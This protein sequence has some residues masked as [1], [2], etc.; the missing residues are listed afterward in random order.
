M[1]KITIVN[2]LTAG[3]IVCSILLL[4]VPAFSVPFYIFYAA[5]GI[6]DMIDGTVARKTHTTSA[7]GAKLDSAADLVF[8]AVC[9][10]RILPV[11]SLPVW[12]LVW[13]GVIVIIR[14][15]GAGIR[16]RKHRRI[17]PEHSVMNKVSGAVVFAVP[18]LLG[19]T[20]S[21]PVKLAGVVVACALATVGAVREVIVRE[22]DER[23]N[24]WKK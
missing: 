3:R 9:M 1:R 12:V 13:I 16:Y 18:L 5:A 17:E 10:F 23:M 15:V 8:V 24:L 22:N 21:Q 14:I 6:T 4:C 11:L 19:M 20:V 7:F 2:G